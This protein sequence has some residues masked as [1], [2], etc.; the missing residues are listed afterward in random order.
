[1]ITKF[2]D[3]TF[4]YAPS[5]RDDIPIW[6]E[7]FLAPHVTQV[8]F[9]IVSLYNTETAQNGFVFLEYRNP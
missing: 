1:M 8:R 4:K 7:L 9:G 2:V 5:I 3:D 6:C